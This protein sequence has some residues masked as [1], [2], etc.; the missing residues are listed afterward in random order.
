MSSHTVAGLHSA[1]KLAGVDRGGHNAS[2][3]TAAN[4]AQPESETPMMIGIA[5]R[6][7]SRSVAGIKFAPYSSSARRAPW[8]GMESN[9]PGAFRDLPP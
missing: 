5:M 4:S 3:K 8:E 9:P 6:A 1:F 2:H 7:G